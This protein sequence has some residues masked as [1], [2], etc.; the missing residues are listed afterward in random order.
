MAGC[1]SNSTQ[2]SIDL[3]K[4]AFKSKADGVL[5]VTPYYN[6]PT[7]QGIIQHFEKIALSCPE[8]LI[9]LYNIPGRSVVEISSETTVKLSKISNIVGVKDATGDLN[10]PLEIHDL[11]GKNFDQI[12][13][14]DSTFLAFLISG[15]IGC[16]SVSANLIPKISAKI[17]NLWKDGKVQEAMK[18][19]HEIYNLNKSLFIETSPAPIKYALSKLSKCKNI[20]RLPLVQVSKETEKKNRYFLKKIKSCLIKVKKDKIIKNR[21]ASY[22]YEI[23]EKVEAGIVLTGPEIKSIRQGKVALDSSYAGEKEGEFWLFN[24]HIDLNKNNSDVKNNDFI[25]PKKLLLKK[26]EI[27]KI[28]HNLKTNGLTV[29]PLDIHF[30][31]KGFAKLNLGLSKG[32]KKAD[33]REYKKKQDWKRTKERMIKI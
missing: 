31:K 17:Y 14:E 12:S 2:E 6:K 29:I 1:G 22:N 20:L 7:Q 30:N 13:G 4:H 23:L 32:R 5:L 10:T 28:L 9:Y 21:K 26:K 8:M 16:I 15:G 11:C 33:L 18:L 24:L 25:R 27:K 3:V 19:N